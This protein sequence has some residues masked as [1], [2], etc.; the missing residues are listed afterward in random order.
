MNSSILRIYLLKTRAK[1]VKKNNKNYIICFS[2]IMNLLVYFGKNL[3]GGE[4]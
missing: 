4:H 3:S 1:R 2:A